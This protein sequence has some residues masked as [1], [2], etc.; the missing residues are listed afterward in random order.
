VVSGDGAESRGLVGP[1]IIE[2][3]RPICAA[4][5]LHNQAVAKRHHH[6]GNTGIKRPL[7]LRR[8][9]SKGNRDA[10]AVLD[11]LLDLAA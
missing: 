3:R 9:W 8:L 4:L 6:P 11:R 10:R 7:C 2:R 1:Q 5:H